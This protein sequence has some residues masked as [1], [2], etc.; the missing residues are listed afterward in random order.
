MTPFIEGSFIVVTIASFMIGMVVGSIITLKKT[1]WEGIKMLE[2]EGE[3]KWK[4]T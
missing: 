2:A 3:Q 4:A 1:L